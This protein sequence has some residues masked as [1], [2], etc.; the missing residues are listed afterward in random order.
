M[1]YA[2]L[3][4]IFVNTMFEIGCKVTTFSRYGQKFFHFASEN[5]PWLAYVRVGSA[6]DQLRPLYNICTILVQYMYNW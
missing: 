4:I 2:S 3:A 6:S 5:G 1:R